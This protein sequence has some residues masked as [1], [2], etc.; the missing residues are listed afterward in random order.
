MFSGGRPCRR[1]KKKWKVAVAANTERQTSGERRPAGLQQHAN[2][3]C[4]TSQ[5]SKKLVDGERAQNPV[6]VDEGSMP[7]HE[8][9]GDLP[10]P[11]VPAETNLKL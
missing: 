9:G 11:D 5:I 6:L 3:R 1:F 7:A 4:G 10:P 2:T 8:A